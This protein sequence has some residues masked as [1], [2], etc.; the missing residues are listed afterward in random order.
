LAFAVAVA[1]Y[2]IYI[3]GYPVLCV[4]VF[5]GSF[6]LLWRAR[7][8]PM[9]GSVLLWDTGEWFLEHCGRRTSVLLQ[10]ASLCHPG[11]I[12]LELRETHGAKRWRLW[13]FSDSAAPERL[14]KLRTRLTLQKG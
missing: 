12:Y 6:I 14:R 4:A 10:P 7:L 1:S 11:V 3:K 13:L 5:V 2:S 8:D 9:V